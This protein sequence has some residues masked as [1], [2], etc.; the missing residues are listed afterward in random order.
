MIKNGAPMVLPDVLSESHK[1]ITRAKPL[2]RR[3]RR[4]VGSLGSFTGS[5]AALGGMPLPTGS[6]AHIGLRDDLRS[7][8]RVAG[9]FDVVAVGVANEGGEVGG[10]VLL[11]E[12]GRVHQL[13]AEPLGS[14]G[15]V[16]NLLPC[17]GA[18]TD[19]QVQ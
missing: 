16:L 5:I 1:P 2:S 4:P 10:M 14:G 13:G 17:I 9:G 19:V 6:R 3:V 8:G 18:E 12:L 11:K 15:K 7:A